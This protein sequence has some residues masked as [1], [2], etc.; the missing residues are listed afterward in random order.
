MPKIPKHYSMILDFRKDLFLKLKEKKITY[1]DI[2]NSSFHYLLQFK[3]KPL[4][5][6]HD[7]DSVLLN[8]FYWQIQV[9]RRIAV[10]RQLRDNGLG[11]EDTYRKNVDIYIKRRDQMVRRLIWELEVE[12]ESIGLI[13]DN[14]VEIKIK[15]G[16]IIY[17]S[18]ESLEKIRL[19]CNQFKKSLQ[20]EYLPL[21]I[22]NEEMLNF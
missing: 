4:A 13:F 9:E 22:F 20:R 7:I 12:I 5:K 8:Y 14:I 16:I 15:P 17:S 10:E 3:I 2:A 1:E 18:R 21:I 6:A 11:S 19:S